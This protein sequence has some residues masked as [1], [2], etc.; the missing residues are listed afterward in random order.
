MHCSS[1]QEA[2]IL[3]EEQNNTT[4]RAT[5]EEWS[6]QGC[7]HCLGLQLNKRENQQ[8][9]MDGLLQSSTTGEFTAAKRKTKLSESGVKAKWRR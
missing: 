8:W 2:Y 7:N 3:I 1:A 9:N 6:F 5:E 4:L